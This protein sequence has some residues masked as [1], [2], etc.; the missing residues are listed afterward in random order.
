MPPLPVRNVITPVSTYFTG[1]A[2]SE[3]TGHLS[4]DDVVHGSP[5][6][7]ARPRLLS[8]RLAAPSPLKRERFCSAPM[9]ERP[10]FRAALPMLRLLPTNPL[11]L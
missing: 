1:V 7:L 4:V 2:R 8:I 11:L 3:A 9:L 10:S 6:M 5:A